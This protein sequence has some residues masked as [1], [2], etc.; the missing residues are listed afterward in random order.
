MVCTQCG[1]CTG[2]GCTD[3]RF[4]LFLQQSQETR[5]GDGNTRTRT[6]SLSPLSRCF[7][8]F[9]RHSF[10]HSDSL[11]L[12][13]CNQ[14]VTLSAR[15]FI[16]VQLTMHKQINSLSTGA[17]PSPTRRTSLIILVS[18]PKRANTT[19]TLPVA[20]ADVYKEALERFGRFCNMLRSVIRPLRALHCPRTLL[21]Y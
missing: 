14:Q 7:K 8:S 13:L 19:T 16:R 11:S 12:A 1:R 21:I 20:K 3:K 5:D 4:G 15:S 9:H 6:H 17:Y 2:S 18:A 10:S